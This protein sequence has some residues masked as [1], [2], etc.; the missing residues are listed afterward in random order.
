MNAVLKI[1]IEGAEC[2]AI[3][4]SPQ[5]L[6]K[7]KEMYVPLVIME[8]VFADPD[9]NCSPERVQEMTDVLYERGYRAFT[10]DRLKTLDMKD[11]YAWPQM[12]TVDFIHVDAKFFPKV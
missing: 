9:I 4:G 8:W 2:D 10:E 6:G 5:V 11:S 12:R 3:I 1:D 7:S